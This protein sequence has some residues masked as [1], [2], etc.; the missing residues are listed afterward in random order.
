M[1]LHI[2]LFV[3]KAFFHK[4]SRIFWQYLKTFFIHTFLGWICGVHFGKCRKL[5]TRIA[6]LWSTH[7][8]YHFNFISPKMQEEGL[9]K[10]SYFCFLEK[11]FCYA[12]WLLTGLQ[13]RFLF[14][15]KWFLPSWKLLCFLEKKFEWLPIQIWFFN[16]PW[17]IFGRLGS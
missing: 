15:Q 14:F 4:N 17:I 11:Q 3:T 13:L 16:W 8:T 6:K 7:S 12:W 9:W 2:V 10:R 1:W 5:P